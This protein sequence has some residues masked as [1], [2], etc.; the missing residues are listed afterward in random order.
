MMLS[1]RLEYE[2]EVT[3]ILRLHDNEAA[4]IWCIHVYFGALIKINYVICTLS[5]KICT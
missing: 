5:H 4:L 3:D 2:D 1:I